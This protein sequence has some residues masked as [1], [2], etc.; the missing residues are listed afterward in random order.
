ML[1]WKTKL[2]YFAVTALTILSAI[3]G[4]FEGFSW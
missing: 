2:T 4:F 1:H 3:A